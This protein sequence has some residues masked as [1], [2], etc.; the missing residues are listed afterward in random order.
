MTKDK[1]NIFKLKQEE[2]NK[3]IET[4]FFDCIPGAEEYAECIKNTITYKETPYVLMLN[5]NFGMGKTFFSTRF[6]QYLKNCKINCIYFSAWEND[7][8]ENPFQAFSKE[9]LLY[10]NNLTLSKRLKSR[11]Q[12]LTIAILEL[13]LNVSKATQIPGVDGSKTV[14]AAEIFLNNFIKE[15]D[16]IN[17]FKDLLNNFINNLENKKL[18][19]IIDEL[20]RCRPD[21]AMKTLEIIKHFFDIEGLFIIVPTNEESLNRCVQSLYGFEDNENST[22]ESYFKKFF[23]DI[24]TLYQPNYLAMVQNIINEKSLGKCILSEG[25][26]LDDE[27][28]NS[29]SKL[30]EHLSNFGE[31][32]HLTIREMHAIC[33]KVIYYCNV[34]DKKIDCEYLSFLLCKKASRQKNNQNRLSDEHPFYKGGKKNKLLSLNIPDKIFVGYNYNAS[35]FKSYY[36]TF[37]DKNFESYNEFKTFYVKAMEE[38]ENNFKPTAQGGFYKSYEQYKNVVKDFIISLKQD[39]ETYQDYWDSDDNDAERQAFYDE[40]TQNDYKLFK[41]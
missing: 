11:L 28:Y 35:E 31:K 21:Y 32:E 37:R 18:V 16:S 17:K 40:I 6:T 38:I 23:D 39:I 30:Q 7:Y 19:L 25:I 27:E 22:R 1:A 13:I 2:Q 26:S 3:Y 41:K 15:K 4:P 34:I 33:S 29:L 9:I 12:N 14:E 10:F 8:L 20:D 36:P 24:E 5:E